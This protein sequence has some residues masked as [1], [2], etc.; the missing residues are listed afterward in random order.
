MSARGF[1]SATIGR[2][3]FASS[4]HSLRLHGFALKEIKSV[5]TDDGEMISSTA[6]RQHVLQGRLERAAAMLGRPFSILGTVEKGDGVGHQLGYPTANLDPHNEIMPPDGVY[7]VHVLIGNEKLGGVVNIGV[8]P[9]FTA[10]DHRR[11]LEVHLFEFQRDIYGE[12]LEVVFL[13]KLREEKKFESADALRKQIAL[14]E[15][16][17]REIVG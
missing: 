8:R 12:D 1:A 7:A 14:D 16:A 9:T 3:T 17:A 6:V 11:V 13:R 4:K 5:H 2:A 10:R 15:R